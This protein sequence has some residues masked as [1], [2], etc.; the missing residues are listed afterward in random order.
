MREVAPYSNMGL[1][2]IIPILGGVFGGQALD[3]HYGTGSMWTIILSV[4]GIAI[5][6][7]V[8]I[9]QALGMNKKK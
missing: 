8:F 4:S 7:Y 9:R 2:L 5:G 6:M 3:E 1:Q